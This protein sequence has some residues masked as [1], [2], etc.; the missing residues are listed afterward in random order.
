MAAKERRKFPRIPICDPISCIAMDSD[1]NYLGQYLGTVQNVSQNGIKIKTFQALDSDFAK[2]S[3][4][5]L[6]KNLVEINGR[7]VY[8]HQGQS[9][10]FESGICLQ[11]TSPEKIQFIKKL[12]I[13]Y[14]HT[15]KTSRNFVHSPSCD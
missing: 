1:G 7:V 8:C 14:H 15:K 5:D 11:G 2:L 9:G 12:V 6:E 4:I 13:S 10:E 3:F